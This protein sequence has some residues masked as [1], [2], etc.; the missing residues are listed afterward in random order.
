M[1]RKYVLTKECQCEADFCPVS[2]RIPIMESPEKYGWF[3]GSLLDTKWMLCPI[4]KPYD[5]FQKKTTDWALECFGE[6]SVHST[7]ERFDRFI[8]ESVEFAQSCGYT[9]ENVLAMVDYV[10]NEKIPGEPN[11]E[12]GGVMVTLA[13]LCEAVHLD[14]NSAGDLEL[15]RVRHK[16]NEIRKKNTS[17]P[18][19][20][21]G[22]LDT[23]PVNWLCADKEY[24]ET[25]TVESL[26][27]S[28]EKK[29]LKDFALDL[30]F[31]PSKIAEETDTICGKPVGSKPYWLGSDQWDPCYCLLI[32][33]HIGDCKCKHMLEE[34][35]DDNMD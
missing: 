34:D 12:L 17:K 27:F 18:R 7:Q 29:S 20:H 2:I 10:Y 4:H 8:E 30:G 31:K 22:N 26:T 13:V 32:N 9:K 11:Q 5:S 15:Q 14:M 24:M 16:I 35:S 21:V 6:E 19:S 1:K 3:K 33:L 28:K 25:K 23:N